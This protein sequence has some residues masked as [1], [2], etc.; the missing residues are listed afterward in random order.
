MESR[1][2]YYRFFDS[3]DYYWNIYNYCVKAVNTN[4]I[5][6]Q[7]VTRQFPELCLA[8][9]KNNGIALKYVQYQSHMLCME[10]IKQNGMH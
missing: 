2:I 8:A 6:L 10:A 7:Y 5:A 9:V 3:I 4:S 1:S